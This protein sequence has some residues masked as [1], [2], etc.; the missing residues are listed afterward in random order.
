M[1]Q[2]RVHHIKPTTGGRQP[3]LYIGGPEHI[4]EC[5]LAKRGEYRKTIQH[6][7]V[8]TNY[9]RRSISEAGSYEGCHRL[10]SRVS[11]APMVT[12]LLGSKIC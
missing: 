12:W 9:R 8:D 3:T 4:L 7:R 5:S 6:P 1:Y 10:P 11:P 2:S